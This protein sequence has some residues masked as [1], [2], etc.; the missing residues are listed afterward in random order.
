MNLIESVSEGF[1]SY[2]STYTLVSPT[3]TTLKGY[4]LEFESSMNESFVSE[5]S[6]KYFSYIHSLKM[7]FFVT[8]F[9]HI[10]RLH[11]NII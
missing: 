7:I 6:R 3:P 11:N 2:S 8:Q 4:L 1:P 9:G 5:Y 10:E